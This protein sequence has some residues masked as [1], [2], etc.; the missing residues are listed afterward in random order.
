MKLIVMCL[1]TLA[2]FGCIGKKQSLKLFCS[3][4]IGQLMETS[5][6]ADI[7]FNSQSSTFKVT[8]N[9]NGATLRVHSSNC[10]TISTDI[11]E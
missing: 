11:Q 10:V 8:S 9:Q 1:L 2:L 3:T 7:T 6:T 4:P 5:D